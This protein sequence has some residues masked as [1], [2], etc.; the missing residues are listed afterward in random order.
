MI[1]LL[2]Y[3]QKSERA[4]TAVDRYGR[5]GLLEVYLIEI[6]YLL[7]LLSY[8]VRLTLGKAY[9]C[10]EQYARV[11]LRGIGQDGIDIRLPCGFSRTEI[12]HSDAH[13]AFAQLEHRADHERFY[14]VRGT[15]PDLTCS[16]KEVEII[17]DEARVDLLLVSFELVYYCLL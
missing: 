3:I 2:L 16:C 7:D 13:Y 15:V 8:P 5:G 14:D 1:L 12:D 17:Y 9:G 4:G 11:D 6:H 10:H